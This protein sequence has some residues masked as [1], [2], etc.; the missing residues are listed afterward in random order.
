[1]V[2]IRIITLESLLRNIRVYAK[3]VNTK[4]NGVADSL[5]RLEFSRFRC[6]AP[7]M[8]S[9]PTDIPTE[10]WPMRKIWLQG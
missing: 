8:N 10:I 2:L 6:L 5:P 4:A 7:D 1:M 9:Y 3:Y